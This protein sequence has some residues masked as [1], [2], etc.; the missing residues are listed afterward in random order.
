MCIFAVFVD[1]VQRL[2]GEKTISFSTIEEIISQIIKILS[3]MRKNEFVSIY[4][5]IVYKRQLDISEIIFLERD[6]ERFQSFVRW[7]R[8]CC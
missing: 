6:I 1:K 2:K 4:I 7:I 5:Y 8:H 3:L